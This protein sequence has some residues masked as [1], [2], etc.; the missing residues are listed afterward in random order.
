[1]IHKKKGERKIMNINY[2]Y[3]TVKV[4]AVQAGFGADDAQYIAYF[5]QHV[6][7]FIMHS[8]FIL[9]S[10][11]PE[12][13]IRNKLAQPLTTGKRWAFAPCATGIN[14]IRT[15]SS[16]YRLT[17]LMPFHFIMPQPYQHLHKNAERSL[18]RCVT[19][20][21]GGDLLINRLFDDLR[22]GD[23]LALGMLLH[24][25]AD[26]YAHEGFSGFQ[27][28]ENAAYAHEGMRHSEAVFFRALPSI[29]HANVGTAPDECDL[30][31]DLYAKR[32]EKG[33]FESFIKR[34]NM[35]YFADCSRRILDI[36]CKINKKPPFDNRQ[37]NALQARLAEAQRGDNWGQSFP[38]IQFAYKK[39]E[40]VKI[41]LEIL[42]HDTNILNYLKI[43][44]DDLYD[45]Y[46]EKSD[47][48]RLSAILTARDVN[49]DFYR[50]NEAAYRHV[51]RT[52]GDYC[53]P[54]HR[55]QLASYCK[56]AEAI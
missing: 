32:T 19:A 30:S 28:W 56:M 13:F 37:W 26:T 51:Y 41:G 39:D 23:L 54:S 33:N 55:T 20:N 38:G 9:D 5:S 6:D 34:D 42:R 8:P 35:I 43:K 16:G 17:A 18:Y 31:I 15:L 53:T 50:F 25:F 40:F 29:G 21:R 27:G 24:T 10:E 22:K 45:V 7:D 48:G 12:F 3:H 46:G 14:E 1:M 52:T 44:A 36:L 2:H 11:P 47:R 4:L 49:N